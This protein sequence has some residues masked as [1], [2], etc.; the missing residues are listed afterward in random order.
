M[1]LLH[2]GN[3]GRSTWGPSHAPRSKMPERLAFKREE[4]SRFRLIEQETADR[5]GFRCHATEDAGKARPG[6]SGR[7]FR[8][9]CVPPGEHTLPTAPVKSSCGAGV[10][11][12]SSQ[13]ELQN[14]CPEVVRATAIGAKGGKTF[15]TRLPDQNGAAYPALPEAVAHGVAGRARRMSKAFAPKGP[16]AVLRRF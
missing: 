15:F 5:G 12:A 16:A 14:S 1:A 8:S 7:A 4:V 3:A 11:D 13:V 10:F 9:L 6:A 2:F